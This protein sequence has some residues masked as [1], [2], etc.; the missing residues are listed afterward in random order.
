MAWASNFPRISSRSRKEKTLDWG[1][2]LFSSFIQGYTILSF[3]ALRNDEWVPKDKGKVC[4]MHFDMDDYR[5]SS[6]HKWYAYKY[7]LLRIMYNIFVFLDRKLLK[8][9]AVP[10]LNLSLR[11]LTET[12]IAD[13]FDLSDNGHERPHSALKENDAQGESRKRISNIIVVDLTKDKKAKYP[14]RPKVIAKTL[15]YVGEFGNLYIFICSPL[16]STRVVLLVWKWWKISE[17]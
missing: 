14:D 3:Q 11:K 8:P 4:S 16:S 1:E 7:S 6:N 10:S 12:E 15:I 5:E 17:K 2:Q 9:N 13:H